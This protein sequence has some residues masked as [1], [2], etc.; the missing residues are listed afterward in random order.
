MPKQKYQHPL[1]HYA[2]EYDVSPRT[3]GEWSRKKAP[4]D[5]PDLMGEWIAVKR[6][7][8][9]PR[10]K[11]D[12]AGEFKE[13]P[14]PQERP[15]EEEPPE[16]AVVSFEDIPRG[17]APALKRLEE[18]EA[19]FYQRLAAAFASGNAD[20]IANAREDWLKCSES[21]RKYDLLV[22]QSRRDSGELIPREEAENAVLMGASW[23]R[24]AVML[25]I[26]SDVPELL[27]IK[28]GGEL[29]DRI[30]TGLTGALE[31]QMGNASNARVQLPAWAVSKLREGFNAD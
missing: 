27:S 4:L 13:D 14:Y 30:V 31:V 24:L 29:G 3:I 1:S 26:S 2:A 22:E 11:Q 28:D 20:R 15:P 23:L 6:R 21:L 9:G 18:N 19:K 12:P 25:F 5:N 8:G 7:G 16:E 17:A 10:G